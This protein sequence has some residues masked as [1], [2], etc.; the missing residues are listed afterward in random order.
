MKLTC[1]PPGKTEVPTMSISVK[2]KTI[3]YRS[4]WSLPICN[5]RIKNPGDREIHTKQGSNE[6]RRVL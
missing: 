4:P 1:N 2:Y 3:T 5:V 6:R